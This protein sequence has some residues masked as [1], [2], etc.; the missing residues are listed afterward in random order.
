VLLFFYRL[1]SGSFVVEAEAHDGWAHRLRRKKR[2][3][4]IAREL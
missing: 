3:S 1:L 4:A 2:R